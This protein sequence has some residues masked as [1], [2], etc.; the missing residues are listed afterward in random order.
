MTRYL[1]LSSLG[2][3]RKSVRVSSLRAPSKGYVS[4][5]GMLSIEH[6]ALEEANERRAH[7]IHLSK[8]G[9]SA[10]WNSEEGEVLWIDGQRLDPL[11]KT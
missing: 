4:H 6:A 2:G 7:D 10:F 1:T 8:E 3:R 11:H 9:V 5:W